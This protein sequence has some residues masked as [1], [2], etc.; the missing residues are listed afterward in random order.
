MAALIITLPGIADCCVYRAQVGNGTCL[1]AGV[2]S[3]GVT[4]LSWDY[5]A[6]TTQTGCVC[7]NAWTDPEG[8]ASRTWCRLKWLPV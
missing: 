2:R 1:A 5:C 4:D 7:A 8:E 6:V 3:P